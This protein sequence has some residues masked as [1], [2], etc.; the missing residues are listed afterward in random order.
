MKWRWSAIGWFV[1]ICGILIPAT[2]LTFW[3]PKVELS[4]LFWLKLA[5]LPLSVWRMYRLIACDTGPFSILRWLRVK[6]GVNYP[7]KEDGSTDWSHWSTNDGSFAEG[8][9]CS[10]CAPIWWSEL[11]TMIMLYWSSKLFLFIA[12]PLNM[13]AFTLVFE[14][15]IYAPRVKD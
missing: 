14:N 7:K 6:M 3:F 2:V 1:L 5:L 10:K 15:I 13:S 4:T 12:I 9:T 11:F 8:M